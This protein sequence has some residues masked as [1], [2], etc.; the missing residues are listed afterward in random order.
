MNLSN[1]TQ[2]KKLIAFKLLHRTHLQATHNVALLKNPKQQISICCPPHNFLQEAVHLCYVKLQ[3]WLGTDTSIWSKKCLIAWQRSRL[4]EHCASWGFFASSRPFS[5]WP[6]SSLWRYAPVNTRFRKF[7]AGRSKSTLENSIQINI[8]MD[9]WLILYDLIGTPCCSQFILGWYYEHI[10]GFIL[11]VHTAPATLLNIIAQACPI[12]VLT[13]L[14]K[15]RSCREATRL[16][17]DTTLYWIWKIVL[18]FQF[19]F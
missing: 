13:N 2:Q 16:C 15:V 9:E 17:Y 5:S 18:H 1:P 8:F 7:L 6:R 3:R 11:Q 4:S 12:N 14:D 19:S 10:N